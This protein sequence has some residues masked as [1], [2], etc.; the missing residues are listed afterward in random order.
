MFSL[1]RELLAFELRMNL[2]FHSGFYHSYLF[3]LRTISWVG[4]SPLT[5]DIQNRAAYMVMTLHF[6]VKTSKYGGRHEIKKMLQIE[7]ASRA[8]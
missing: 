3:I 6:Q 5:Q 7:M 1:G 4:T 8:S 2:T